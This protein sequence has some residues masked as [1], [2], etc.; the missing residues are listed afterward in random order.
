MLGAEWHAARAFSLAAISFR[1]LWAMVDCGSSRHCHFVCLQMSIKT[2]N[3]YGDIGR[4]N[5]GSVVSYFG[6]RF[7][8]RIVVNN[9]VDGDRVEH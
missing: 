8:K 3:S 1:C 9:T 5:F 7:L 4:S 2:L 6:T